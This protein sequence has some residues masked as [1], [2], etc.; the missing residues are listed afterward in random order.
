M[1]Q[2]AQQKKKILIQL[3]DKV[4]IPETGSCSLFQGNIPETGYRSLFQGFD[5]S[6]AACGLRFF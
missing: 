1:R 3:V 2:S 4:R 6:K 5:K